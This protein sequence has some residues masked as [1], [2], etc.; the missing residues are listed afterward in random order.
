MVLQYLAVAVCHFSSFGFH[1][2]KKHVVAF[3]FFYS[4]TEIYGKMRKNKTEKASSLKARAKPIVFQMTSG[5]EIDWDARFDVRASLKDYELLSLSLF[6]LSFASL[7]W[8]RQAWEF[9]KLFCQK[10][11]RKLNDL[12]YHFFCMY[13]NMRIPFWDYETNAWFSGPWR[14]SVYNLLCTAKFL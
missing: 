11:R 14:N 13:D 6:R 12:P 8:W 4:K 7:R 3:S 10:R 5:K 1:P 9:F 2:W